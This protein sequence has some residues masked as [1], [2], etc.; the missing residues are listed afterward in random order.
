MTKELANRPEQS[1]EQGLGLGG[2]QFKKYTTLRVDNGD[3]KKGKNATGEF[4]EK[5]KDE[6]GEFVRVQHG[7]KLDGVIL[8]AMARL[9]EKYQDGKKSW[10][11]REFNPMFVNK[12]S[13]IPVDIYRGKNKIATATYGQIQKSNSTRNSDGTF[14][15]NFVYT[16]VLYILV[17]KEIMKLELTG[18]SRSNWFDYSGM[19]RQNEVSLLTTQTA[20]EVVDDAEGNYSATFTKGDAVEYEDIKPFAE[21]LKEDIIQRHTGDEEYGDDVP[22]IN[23]DEEETG[24]QTTGNDSREAMST[25]KPI[26]A[27]EKEEEEIRIEDVPF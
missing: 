25:G 5:W 4:V 2:G 9:T 16:T 19:L 10:Y 13:K 22:T 14:V 27:G 3:N 12:K 26:N 15:N 7:K 23:L 6:A 1:L 18:K 24:Y 21:E 17:D 8:A 20:L 11:T